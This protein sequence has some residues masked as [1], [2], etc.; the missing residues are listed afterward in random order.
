MINYR[1][2]LFPFPSGQ[3]FCQLFPPHSLNKEKHA[4]MKNDLFKFNFSEI[5]FRGSSIPRQQF[6]R[7]IASAS[8]YLTHI[9]ANSGSPFFFLISDNSYKSAVY[10]F[11][12]LKAGKIAVL[13]DP[14]TTDRELHDLMMT[15]QPCAILYPDNTADAF[16]YEA[17]SFIIAAGNASVRYKQLDDV[18]T[19]M[20]TNAEDG[21]M[22]AVML[23]SENIETG[24]K[25]CFY[26]DTYNS[27]SCICGLIP[28]FHIYGLITGL[29]LGTRCGGKFII[30]EM[31]KALDV[32]GMADTFS[33]H[34]ITNLYSVP[35]VYYL[36]A[37]SPTAEGF[38]SHLRNAVSGGYKLSKQINDQFAAKTG[39]YIKEGYGITE[40]TG[41]VYTH[42]A[43]DE[44]RMDSVGCP[45][46]FTRT[47]IINERGAE[48]EHG[49]IGEICLSGT[50]IAKG[51]YANNKA[52][53]EFF[54][55]GWLHTGDYGFVDTDGYLYLTGLKKR[56]L[57]VAGKNVYPAE[58]ERYMHESGLVISCRIYG[59]Y[60]GIFGHKVIAEIQLRDPSPENE[61]NIKQ[62]CRDNISG[63]KLPKR[64]EF[65][66]IE[67]AEETPVAAKK[68]V[69]SKKQA[70]TH[71]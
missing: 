45:I 47:S 5:V 18:C 7:D 43:S 30:Y 40:A 29:F 24:L 42:K 59:E 17:E 62:W 34:R 39:C 12:I 38:R 56:M 9:S 46:P 25:S 54:K 20:F 66:Q 57:N 27:T 2:I 60:T 53:K 48:I 61:S 10:Y 33:V 31:S 71:N 37:K 6:E 11:A 23:T 69:K 44:L 16:S 22:K 55:D 32:Q 70:L 36:L 50:G 49:L 65:K 26:S 51:Y 1:R 19:I 14:D 41:I 13:A 68:A 28:F 63:Y 8:E 58:L 21:N 35:L 3:Y 52:T 15:V 64:W 67:I 4:A